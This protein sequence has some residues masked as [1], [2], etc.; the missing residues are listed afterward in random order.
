MISDSS[1]LIFACACFY[2]PNFLCVGESWPNNNRT[3]VRLDNQSAAV[4]S[5]I[6]LAGLKLSGGVINLGGERETTSLRVVAA[7][8]QV[9]P[10]GHLVGKI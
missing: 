6:N 7:C 5:V 10:P 8:F 2:T 9:P 4:V 3:S 1:D